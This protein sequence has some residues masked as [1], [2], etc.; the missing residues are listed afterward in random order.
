MHVTVRVHNSAA[1]KAEFKAWRKS[2]PGTAEDRKRWATWYL[3]SLAQSVIRGQ[4]SGMTATEQGSDIWVWEMIKGTWFTFAIH[5]PT[6]NH[7]EFLILS[8]TNHPPPQGRQ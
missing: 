5:R 7:V 1:A 4:A 2:L 3:E 8:V 6:S